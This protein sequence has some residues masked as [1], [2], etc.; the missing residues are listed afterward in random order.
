MRRRVCNQTSLCT[1]LNTRPDV[2]VACQGRLTSDLYEI[3]KYRRSCDADLSDDH[4]AAP[5]F[6]IVPDLHKIIDPTA[7][8]DDRIGHRAPINR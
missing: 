7:R 6:Y 3:F 5:Y 2:Q 1:D 8:S 4:A